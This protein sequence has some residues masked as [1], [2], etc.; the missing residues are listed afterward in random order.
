MMQEAVLAAVRQE[1]P[2][3]DMLE[4]KLGEPVSHPETELLLMGNKMKVSDFVRDTAGDV[5][6]AE[7]RK[8]HK[9]TRFLLM[10]S[11]TQ[12]AQTLSLPERLKI[13]EAVG[14]IALGN[15]QRGRV[16]DAA[17]DISDGDVDTEN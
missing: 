9:A 5:M 11:F 4:R 16:T 8:G 3:K 13:E 6:R 14:R 17:D 1:A 15:K 12:A 7:M 2:V 10:Q